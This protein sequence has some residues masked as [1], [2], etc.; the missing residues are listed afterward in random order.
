MAVSM[1]V[2]LYSMPLMTL[3]VCL[4]AGHE[5]DHGTSI[6]GLPWGG[7]GEG[8][9]SQLP[10]GNHHA[11]PRC[12]CDRQG[13]P[14]GHFRRGARGQETLPAE[15]AQGEDGASLVF[16][17]RSFTEHSSSFV[18]VWWRANCPGEDG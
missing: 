5:S 14:D 6:G 11:S 12:S 18:F 7:D 2:L 17:V 13:D 8:Q 16:L 3:L 15:V 4:S 1:V 9:G 10:D